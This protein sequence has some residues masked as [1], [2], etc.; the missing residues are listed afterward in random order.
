MRKLNMEIN[1]FILI[2]PSHFYFLH[3]Q[4]SQLNQRYLN[5]FSKIFLSSD[6]IQKLNLEEGCKVKVSNEFGSGIYI[7]TKSPILKPKTALIY[8]GLPS[9]SQ[10]GINVNYFIS[11]KPE[12]LGFSGAYNSAIIKIDKIDT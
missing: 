9:P 4:L 8:S 6:D 11:D 3:S 1:E 12:E 10:K 7:L 2:S 5:E